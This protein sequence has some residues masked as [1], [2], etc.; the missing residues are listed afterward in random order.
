MANSQVRV[1]LESCQRPRSLPQR[2]QRQ[3]QQQ[4]NFPRKDP[5]TKTKAHTHTYTHSPN[6][7]ARV[8]ACVRVGDFMWVLLC[9]C[10]WKRGTPP[11]TF[12]LLAMWTN[13]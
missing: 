5:R 3:Q 6:S 13:W 4:S 9:A 2:Q 10:G 7:R 11:K 8:Y 12:E 1:L